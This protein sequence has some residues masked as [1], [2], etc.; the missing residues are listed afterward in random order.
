MGKSGCGKTTLMKLLGFIDK[1]TSG[2]IIFKGGV[3][4]SLIRMKLQIF[5]GKKLVLCFRISI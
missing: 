5:E 2:E 1:P 3:Q 4:G